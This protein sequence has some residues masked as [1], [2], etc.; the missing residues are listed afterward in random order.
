MGR[1]TSVAGP[2]VEPAGTGG[3][4]RWGMTAWLVAER[5]LTCLLPPVL[6]L[7]DVITVDRT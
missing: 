5:Q 7:G 3:R 6:S 1:R 4:Q 2:L